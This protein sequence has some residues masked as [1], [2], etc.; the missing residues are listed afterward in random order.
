[1]ATYF[2]IDNEPTSLLKER[3]DKM[4]EEGESKENTNK[5]EDFKNF[6]LIFLKPLLTSLVK[7]KKTKNNQTTSNGGRTSL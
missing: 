7:E 5:I 6:I 1:M 2:A 3:L 4:A